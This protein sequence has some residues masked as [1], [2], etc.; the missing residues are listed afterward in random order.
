MIGRAEN[1]ADAGISHG[2]RLSE[3]C[4][5]FG[6]A[7]ADWLDLS[8]GIN[9]VPWAGATPPPDWHR[10][11][12]PHDLVRLEAM[13]AHTFGVDPA[14]CCAVPGSELGLRVL[15]SGLGLPGHYRAPCYSSYADAFGDARQVSAPD[16]LPP[17]PRVMVLGNPNNPD[18][19]INTERELRGWQ[20]AVREGWLIVDEAFA[21]ATPDFRSVAPWVKHG[22]RLIVLRSF[23]K[24]F[25]LAGARLG[26]VI[27]PPDVLALVRRGQGAWPVGAGALALGLAAY[28][29]SA[30]IAA[31]RARLQSS[32]AALDAVLARHGLPPFGAC[33]LF[34]LVHNERAAA[35]FEALAR[36]HILTRPFTD[37]PRALRFGLPAGPAD[38]ARLDG[39]LARG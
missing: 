9:P 13:A 37:Q 3:A 33:P 2:G 14:L 35:L 1:L 23:G 21:E 11:P 36:D 15:A 6:G 30:W 16:D 38:L 27:A 22:E 32:A 12:D 19:R 26:F 5:R 28:A 20:N 18:G 7:P 10:L 17:G 39:A 29:D 4:A 8:T 34:R 31:T 24:F 25:G